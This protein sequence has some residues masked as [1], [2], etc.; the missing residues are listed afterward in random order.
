MAIMFNAD[1]VFEM[2]VRI[3]S[4]GAAFYRKAA[5]MQSDSEN[6]RFLESLAAM[7]DQHQKIF[8][9]MRKTLTEKDAGGKVFDPYDEVSQYLA[10]M[11]D[12]IGGEGSPSAADALTGSETLEEI[13]TTAIGLEK[14][15]ILFY[16]GLKDLVPP[17]YGQEKIDDIIRQERK[18]VAQLTGHLNKLR[19]K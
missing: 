15:S 9:E 14:D 10:S 19:V 12:T 13:L 4:N 17:K 16:V 5:A 3:E 1:E 8:I 2:A 6:Q 7:E 11:A 18:H